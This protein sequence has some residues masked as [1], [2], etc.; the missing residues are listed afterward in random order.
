MKWEI[1]K[2][3]EMIKIG[4]FNK[5]NTLPPSKKIEP[6]HLPMTEEKKNKLYVIENKIIDIINNSNI[7]DSEF[8]ILLHDLELLEK[9]PIVKFQTR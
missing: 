7:T 2:R 6:W 8:Q 4:P 9:D 3:I 1:P 5:P